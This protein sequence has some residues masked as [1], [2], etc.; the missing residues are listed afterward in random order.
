MAK[1]P[2][3]RP[4]ER[5]QSKENFYQDTQSRLC[6]SVGLYLSD[7]L[8][9]TS[10]MVFLHP[11]AQT[12]VTALLAP[13]APATWVGA[14][15]M[16]ALLAAAV[17]GA[18]SCEHRFAPTPPAP[19]AAPGPG[20]AL[21][22]TRHVRVTWGDAA[23]FAV[24]VATLQGT[25]LEARWV[26]SRL[27]LLVAFAFTVLLDANYNGAIVSALL[28][29]APHSI[30]TLRQLAESPL[31]VGLEDIDYNLAHLQD[32][33]VELLRVRKRPTALPLGEGV[34]RV[35]GGGFAFQAEAPSLFPLLDAQLDD[36][37]RCALAHVLFMPHSMP[38]GAVPRGSP[39][40]EDA[41]H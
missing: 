33:G 31:A 11:P 5:L 30:R 22:P 26:S 8:N 17:R 25:S 9:Y 36:A 38:Y 20:P 27:L 3:D 23:M 34:R 2:P 39:L 32:P 29:P 21:V 4:A 6:Y 7:M 19:R 15:A 1:L 14:A 18:A 10:F 28:A 24:G 16:V 13:F 35:A 41:T 37:G 40:R 12:S